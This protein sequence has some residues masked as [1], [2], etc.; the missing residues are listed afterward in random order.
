MN[1]GSYLLERVLK[2]SAFSLASL[3][4]GKPVTGRQPSAAVTI[5]AGHRIRWVKA[6]IATTGV[7]LGPVRRG[8]SV[9]HRTTSGDSPVALAWTAG[10]LSSGVL[11]LD[12][13]AAESSG[14]S[15]SGG[16]VALGY[17]TLGFLSGTMWTVGSCQIQRFDAEVA[18]EKLRGKRLVFSGDSL[19]RNQWESFVCMVEWTIPP[20]KK[21]L[22]LGK[23]HNV[24]KAKEYNATIE[25]HWA[26]FLVQSNTD[27]NIKEAKKRIIK[28]D[29]VSDTSKDWEGADILAFNTY[30]WWMYGIRV[31]TLW[32]S[33][34]NGEEGY[35]QLD[36]P[37]A[38]KIGLK[39]WANWID[40]NINP[41]KTRVFFTTMSPIHSK[42]EEWGREDGL[43]CFN[44]S[45]PLKKKNFWGNFAANKEMMSAVDEVMK[46]MKVPVSVLNVTQLSMYRVDAHSSIY[47]ET[48]GK[49][50]T[51][52]ERADPK[53]H[54][55]CIHWC[56]P[57]VPD[58]WNQLLFAHL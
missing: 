14:S 53:K 29:S 15:S 40:S 33:F 18:L 22:T 11:G 32:G 42:S 31:K 2:L 55:D 47:T 19:Q 7:R 1:P 6:F 35:A 46:K 57:G 36:T 30:V 39:T 51:P 54:A 20:Q 41:N 4:G 48:G 5:T 44:E 49:L 56:L 38:Y 17:Q 27:I 9:S 21:S 28:V 25:F 16:R 10:I 43:K 24:F 45:E 50:L 8:A 52:E 13:A 3:T 58:T 23:V 12:V 26:P 37:V 34:A